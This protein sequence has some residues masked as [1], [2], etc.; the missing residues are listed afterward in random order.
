MGVLCL[1]L[2][3]LCITKCLFSFYNHLDEKERADC[4]ALIG[5][6]VSCD[7]KC[8]VAFPHGAVGWLWYF[9]IKLTFSADYRMSDLQHDK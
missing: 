8:S 3:L 6:L 7:H 9:L 2:V 4:F 1:V 5:F